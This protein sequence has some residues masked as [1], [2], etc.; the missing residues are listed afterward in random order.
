VSNVIDFPNPVED[1]IAEMFADFA[2]RAREDRFRHAVV[3]ATH[4][5]GSPQYVIRDGGA[6]AVTLLTMIGLLDIAK[7]KLIAMAEEA[8]QEAAQAE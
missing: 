4:A 3:L 1:S 8:Q 2:K 7:A 6:D 5:D